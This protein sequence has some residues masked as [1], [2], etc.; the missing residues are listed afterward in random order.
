MFSIVEGKCGFDVVL[1][2][3]I[4]SNEDESD[5]SSSSKQSSSL[6]SRKK[7]LSTSDLDPFERRKQQALVKAEM[8]L[9]K[10]QRLHKK[11]HECV[12]QKISE[13][14]RSTTLPNVT[15]SVGTQRTMNAAFDKQIQSLQEAKKEL[16]RKITAYQSDITKIQSGEIPESY[17]TSKD[18]ISNLKTTASKVT[19][20]Q[21]KSRNSSPNES[22]L[23]GNE[24]LLPNE[25]DRNFHSS[26]VSSSSPSHNF[27]FQQQFTENNP[28]SHSSST[29]NDLGNSQFYINSTRKKISLNFPTIEFRHVFL[30][31]LINVRESSVSI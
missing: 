12:E 10:A 9:E 7:N 13:F 26:S 27:S 29:S 20:S 17:F 8:K 2:L 11:A 1:F 31:Y 19:G 14:L 6:N 18:F 3:F 4:K 28:S 21:R 30:K 23:N 15:P 24:L 25:A 5:R 22:M 16:E